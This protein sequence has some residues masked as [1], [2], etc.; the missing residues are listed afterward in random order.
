[1]KL[2]N[3]VT[4]IFFAV[5]AVIGLFMPIV[6]YKTALTGSEYN[7]V[8]IFS[9]L[10]GSSSSGAGTLLKNLGIY[11]YKGTAIVAAVG[12]A[13]MLVLLAAS[14]V[15]SFTNAPYLVLTVTTG[16]GFASYVTAIIAF[17][18]IGGAF[19]AG[20]IPISAITSLSGS[21]DVLTSLISSFANIS[22]MGITSGAY[23]G[24]VCLG[25]MFIVNL[26]CFIFRKKLKVMDKDEAEEEQRRKSSKK[27]KKTKKA[28]KSNKE[29]K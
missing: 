6:A 29:S 28:T 12:F 20:A 16:L 4:N 22:E 24:V 17:V 14:L 11:G 26:L 19:V 13:L 10:K 2:T 9:M 27:S 15:I 25:V 5:F 7:I 21:G 18:K 1:M 8:D 23:V 3:K